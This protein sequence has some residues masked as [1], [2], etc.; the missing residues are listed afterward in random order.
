MQYLQWIIKGL[1]MGAA[2]VVPGISGGTLAFILGVY[3][4]LLAAITS[5]N[6]IAVRLLFKGRFKTLWRYIDGNFLLCLFCGILLSI[7]SLASI[8]SWLLIHRPV[9]LWA[10]FNGL[11]LAS[12]PVLFRGMHWNIM[13]YGLFIG[14]IAFAIALG[15]LSPTELTP[16]L[17]MFFIAGAI[18]IC[19]MILPGTSGSFMLLIM[20]M[21][22][23]V[24]LAVTAFNLPVLFTF[25]A[26]CVLGLLS[27]SRFLK[28]LLRYHYD[29][30]MSFLLGIIIGGFVR[31]WPWQHENQFFSPIQYQAQIAPHDAVLAVVCFIGGILLMLVLLNLETLL[32][33]KT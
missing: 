28:W 5:F 18:A 7:F 20:G 29:T 11:M 15:S 33:R 17:W 6:F 24:L 26:G 23:P 3:N 4:R 31:I 12:L 14:G 8:V 9:P 21:Y 10:L 13:R 1:A 2:D 27:F 22:A 25:A 32:K 16:S 19:A 30:S